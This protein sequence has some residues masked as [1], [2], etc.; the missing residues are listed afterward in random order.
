MQGMPRY[1]STNNDTVLTIAV[2][3]LRASDEQLSAAKMRSLETQGQFQV[4]Q[5]TFE[6]RA[7]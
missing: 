6:C 5:A 7:D 3:S 1:I 2:G 4:I